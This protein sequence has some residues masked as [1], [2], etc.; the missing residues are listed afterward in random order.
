MNTINIHLSSPAACIAL[1][2]VYMR[3]NLEYIAKKVAVPN[4]VYSIG[5]IRPDVIMLRTVASSLIMFDSISNI[6]EWLSKSIPA[7][8]KDCVKKKLSLDKNKENPDFPMLLR[9]GLI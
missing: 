4:K 9:V 6:N 5:L 2:F 3:T 8:L 1:A 7:V